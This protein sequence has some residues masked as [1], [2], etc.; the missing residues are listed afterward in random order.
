VR[1]G[2]RIDVRI[3]ALISKANKLRKYSDF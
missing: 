2:A 1:M 3:S